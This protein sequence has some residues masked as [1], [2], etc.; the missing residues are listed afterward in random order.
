MSH[1]GKELWVTGAWN[2]YK[3]INYKHQKLE[4]PLQCNHTD[5][6]RALGS[7]HPSLPLSLHTLQRKLTEKP[8]VSF[9]IRPGF[10]STSFVSFGKDAQT[11][12]TTCVEEV[13]VAL[14]VLDKDI[15]EINVPSS[16]SCF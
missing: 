14:T 12:G 4:N 8:T 10:K 6:P 16:S 11:N 2:T 7:Q 5:L 1:L 3:Y 15:H 13:Y 9:D